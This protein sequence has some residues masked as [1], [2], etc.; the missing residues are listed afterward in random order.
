M[1]QA[2]DA[3]VI[4]SVLGANFRVGLIDRF[5]LFIASSMKASKVLLLVPG[6]APCL[7]LSHKRQAHGLPINASIDP[8][9]THGLCF[10]DVNCGPFPAL[11]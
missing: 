9:D 4:N 3:V 6:C 5:P 10:Q 7:T 1:A 8:E 2:R 11:F